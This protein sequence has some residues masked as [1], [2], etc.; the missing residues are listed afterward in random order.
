MYDKPELLR[1]A[2]FLTGSSN[3]DELIETA[4]KLEGFANS[5]EIATSYSHPLLNGPQ[6]D[7]VAF[8]STLGI[9][10]PTRGIV[11]L[12]LYDFQ[13][14]G[15]QKLQASE[16]ICKTV[17]I[18]N[19]RQ[20]G[21]TTLMGV[22][23]LHYA[24]LNDNTTQLVLGPRLMHS[25]EMADRVRHMLTCRPDVM[26]E[27]R[28]KGELKF[29]N[30]SK[31]L[32]RAATPDA[33]RGT[34]LHKVL[35]SEAAYVSHKSLNEVLTALV[36]ALSTGAQLIMQST[37]NMAHDPFHRFYQTADF[38]LHQAWDLHPDRD[39]AWADAYKLQL[40]EDRFEHEF[41][42]KFIVP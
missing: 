39:Q 20:M 31:I 9:A 35:I 29:A 26:V 12:A 41:E 6:E 34:T 28:S 4:R 27:H 13:R 38:S 15:L 17:A 19:A 24:L 33:T 2:K 36:P 21:W 18:A 14:K 11:P 10:H 22:Y 40:G 23:M 32:F 16:G 30:G 3:I 8:A 7:V 5:S 37:P 25:L 42:A 1:L